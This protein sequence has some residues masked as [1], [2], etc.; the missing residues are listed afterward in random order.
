MCRS[1]KALSLYT[2]LV[3]G[4]ARAQRE[5]L[6]GASDEARIRLREWEQPEAL[7][8]RAVILGPAAS[9]KAYTPPEPG[10]FVTCL[11]LTESQLCI[12]PEHQS[13]RKGAYI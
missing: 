6:E 3:D 8:A 10:T 4:L 2:D 5:A 11:Q 13:F 9:P 7:Q 12:N 1:A